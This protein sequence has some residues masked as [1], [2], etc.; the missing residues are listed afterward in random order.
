MW[1]KILLLLLF[2]F[3]AF[4]GYSDIW[5]ISTFQLNWAPNTF[6]FKSILEY[7][8]IFNAIVNGFDYLNLFFL[9]FIAIP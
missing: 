5:Q 3:I 9:F 8:I 4:I 7:F 1:L 2:W 6:L